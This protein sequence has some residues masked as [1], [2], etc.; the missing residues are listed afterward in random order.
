M[1]SS[2][3]WRSLSARLASK[4]AGGSDTARSLLQN[5]AQNHARRCFMGE[6]WILVGGRDV[7]IGVAKPRPRHQ[8]SNFSSSAEL[9]RLSW[10][11]GVLLATAEGDPRRQ[12][13]GWSS[14]FESLAI[15][16]DLLAV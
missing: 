3:M 14:R 5:H 16:V 12:T 10:L 11:N 15:F 6:K 9:S 1:P 4:L 8:L 7:S 13:R 2:S